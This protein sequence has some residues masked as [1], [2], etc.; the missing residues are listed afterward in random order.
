MSSVIQPWVSEIPFMQQT[1]LL[2]AIRGSDGCP[3]R[4]PSKM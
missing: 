1:V 4:H 3:K 2:T